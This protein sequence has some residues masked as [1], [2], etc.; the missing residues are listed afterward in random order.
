MKFDVFIQFNDMI[1]TMYD[2]FFWKEID[3]DEKT[4]Q[5]VTNKDIFWWEYIKKWA[6]DKQFH[7]Y[8]INAYKVIMTRWI[9]WCYVYA[10]NEWLRKY[11]SKFIDHA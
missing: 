6:S 11:L 4:N 3:Y 8:I 1:W 5:I 10:Y 9:K 7:E 2:W